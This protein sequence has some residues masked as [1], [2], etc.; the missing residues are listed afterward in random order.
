MK[1][2]LGIL[3]LLLSLPLQADEIRPAYLQVTEVQP[4]IFSVLW[5]VPARNNSQRLS[6]AVEFE[7]ENVTVQRPLEGFSAGYHLRSWKFSAADGLPQTNIRING[8]ARTS[9]EVLLRIEYLDGTSLTHR[10][11]PSS[12][13]YT[14]AE[15]PT[16]LQTAYTYLKLGIEHILL[17]FDHLLFVLALLL[18]IDN[19]RKLIVTITFFTLAHSITLSLAALK[20]IHVPVPPVEAVI[21]LSIVFVASEIIRVQ[22]GH[23]SLA[24]RKPWIVAFTFGLLHGLGFAAALS[25]IGLPD[26]AVP[27]A[28]A[29]FNVGVEIGQ[30]IFVFAFIAM[31]WALSRVHFNP[32]VAWGRAPAYFI[33]SLASFWL[34]ERTAGFFI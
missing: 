9:T 10:F 23:S 22:Q 27:L 34:I 1:W 19:T 20:I 8:L 5:K 28:L 2:L 29:L 7:P 11:T 16:L 30:L 15:K 31:G 32:T 21:A 24:Y 18:L 3:F 12:A 4:N 14:V 13:S 25:Q 26:N 33:G 17:G 6:L